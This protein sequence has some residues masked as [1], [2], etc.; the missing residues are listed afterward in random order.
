MNAVGNLATINEKQ[1]E[2][3]RKADDDIG[4]SFCSGFIIIII[5]HSG[6]K[7]IRQT[8]RQDKTNRQT[9]R[10]FDKRLFFCLITC[11][12]GQRHKKIRKRQREELLGRTAR[13]DS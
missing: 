11:L 10:Q 4:R 3:G 7:H 12:K 6:D 1:K 9:D 13:T 2:G 5:V 8:P